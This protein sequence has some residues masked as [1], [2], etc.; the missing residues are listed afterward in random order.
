MVVLPKNGLY[1]IT[2]NMRDAAVLLKKVEQVLKG[3]CALL[4]YRDKTSSSKDRRLRADDI[5]T[6]CLR[7][8]VPLIIN[9][10]AQLALACHAEGVHLGQSDGCIEEVRQL[11]G[12]RAII[13]VTCHHN[14]ELA[15]AAEAQGA[16]YVAFGRFFN[17]STKPGAPLATPAILLE[18]KRSITIPITA[19]GGFTLDN[20]QSIIH[21]GAD[22]I[23]VVDDVFSSENIIQTSLNYA[24]LFRR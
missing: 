14:V 19:I 18:A 5:H 4:Q 15:I 7:Y 23:A 6:L 21:A 12:D 11:L 22:Y 8:G 24:K 10:D 2:P 9:D 13:G 17:S 3:G 16:D 1:A 20:A